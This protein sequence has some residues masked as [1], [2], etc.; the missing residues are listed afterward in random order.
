M[1]T[2]AARIHPLLDATPTDARVLRFDPCEPRRGRAHLECSLE[3]RCNDA[4][5]RAH[6]SSIAWALGLGLMAPD[7]GRSLARLEAA[8]FATLAARAYPELAPEALELA[9]DWITFLFFY[10]DLCDRHASP[11]DAKSLRA[12]EDRLLQL[13]RTPGSRA[14]DEEDPL[15]R[16]L[17]SI[18]ARVSARTGPRWRARFGERFAEYVEGVRW[19]RALRVRRE[20]PSL[21]TYRR[22]R[23]LISAVYPCLDLAALLAGRPAHARAR[24]L[25]EALELMANNYISWVNDI[26]GVDKER[27]E[28]TTANLV[29]VLRHEQALS[30][31]DAIERAIE[32]CNAELRAF[33]SLERELALLG[34]AGEG[35]LVAHVHALQSWMRGNLDWHRETARY[36][37][38]SAAICAVKQRSDVL[39]PIIPN[40]WIAPHAS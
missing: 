15:A 18:L 28:G 19:E 30:W 27:V 39:S 34:I 1:D 36:R 4:R 6:H 38:G 40:T 33:R 11:A 5:A 20:I 9:A 14:R 7:D 21:A 23:P 24:A 17:D 8:R 35:Q 29:L 16:A 22:L 12:A 32:Q 10:D 37:D 3:A 13:A 25:V 2:H 26:Y 31:D